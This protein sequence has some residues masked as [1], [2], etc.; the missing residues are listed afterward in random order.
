[1]HVV[2]PSLLSLVRL[3]Y[4]DAIRALRALRHLALMTFLVCSAGL[5]AQVLVLAGA[6]R[7]YGDAIGGDLIGFAFNLGWLFLFMPYLI[8]LH[9]YV[10][11]DEATPRY[12]FEPYNPRILRFFGS[13]LALS[14]V[15]ALPI[16]ALGT[17]ALSAGG[18]DVWILVVVGAGLVLA[19]LALCLRM[20]ILFPAIAIDAPGATWLNAFHDTR[21]HTLGI[22][23]VYAAVLVPFALVGGAAMAFVFLVVGIV[24]QLFAML[25]FDM[26]SVAVGVLMLT[27]VAL[28]TGLSMGSMAVFVAVA[29]RLYQLLGNHVKEPPLLAHEA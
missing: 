20:T 7:R 27:T 15:S 3:A 5:L 6:S 19:P 24:L 28:V 4:R 17:L 26:R 9:R 22:F 23:L 11:L 29:S 18:L 8:A 14:F 13:W 1:M 25:L 21:G 2:K 16:L 12:L 10:L